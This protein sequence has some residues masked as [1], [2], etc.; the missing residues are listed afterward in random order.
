MSK[1]DLYNKLKNNIS[2]D[3]D[4]RYYIETNESGS[5][6][7]CNIDLFATGGFGG[8]VISL[9]DIQSRVKK[10]VADIRIMASKSSLISLS[11]HDYNNMSFKIN[12]KYFYCKDIKSKIETSGKYCHAII[13]ALDLNCVGIWWGDNQIEDELCNYIKNKMYF[14]ITNDIIYNSINKFSLGK[15]F[16]NNENYKN[17]IVYY[18]YNYDN[19]NKFNLNDV[20]VP[21]EYYQYSTNYNWDDIGSMDDYINVF[22]KNI[23]YKL[24]NNI[25]TL[26]NPNNISRYM[27]DGKVKPYKGQIPVIQSGIEV[28]KNNKSL[29][30]SS[31]M[32]YG[33]SLITL[34][35]LN[36]YFKEKN[37][38]NYS[39]LIIAPAITLVQWKNEISNAIKEKCDVYI[40]RSTND[41]IDMYKKNIDKPTFYIVGKETFKLDS[42]KNPGVNYKVIEIKIHDDRRPW[43][44]STVKNNFAICPLCGKPI[45]NTF[46]KKRTEYLTKE[47]FESGKP[48]KSNYKCNNCGAVLWQNTYEKTKKTSLINYIKVKNISFNMVVCDEAHEGNKNSSIIGN[49]TKTI[50]RSSKKCILL[51]GTMN[52]GYASSLHNILMAIVPQKLKADKCLNIK[53]FISKYGT[54]SATLDK[55]DK[56]YR[57]SGKIELAD[58]RFNEVEGINPV[59]FT[60]YFSENFIFSTLK[61][62]EKDLPDID[63][64]YIPIQQNDDVINNTNKLIS[65]FKNADSFNYKMYEDSIVKH[66]LNN[67]YEW[68]CIPVKDSVVYPTNINRDSLLPKENVV[69]DICKKEVLE[70]RKCWIYTDFTGENGSGQYMIGKNIVYYL[71]KMLEDNGVK[72]FWLKPNVSPIDRKE[73]ID[74]NKD[75]YDVFISNPKLVNVG[76][77]MEWCGTYIVFTPSYRMDIIEQATHRGYRANSNIKNKIY[78]LYYE[79]SIEKAINERYQRKLAESRAIEGKFDVEIEKDDIRTAS[80]FSKHLNDIFSKM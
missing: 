19:N 36:S 43:I 48:K 74:N 69:L 34:W 71:K 21:K 45:L 1:E 22:Y 11:I 5:V 56:D 47:D 53:D 68:D 67:P 28:L 15:T 44:Y 62:L 23:E 39:V 40:I 6:S 4:A 26:F 42:K 52:N 30:L 51:S 80:K 70:K 33:K 8:I 20:D 60:K 13:Y 25:K 55:E 72:V 16:T 38:N 78:I 9:Y 18:F 77:N 50:L 66:Y 79:N 12:E 75:K 63:T 73:L 2:Y 57:V 54:L 31:Q 65:D 7:S 58:G 61:D 37:K 49:A 59:V 17:F 64:T 3:K 41:F 14:P 27:F 46:V 29:Y 35:I 24:K 76:I 10:V 32:G